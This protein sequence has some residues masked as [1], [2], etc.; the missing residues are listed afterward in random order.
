MGEL[1]TRGALNRLQPRIPK[2]AAIQSI[3]NPG[4]GLA[5]DYGVGVTILDAN[6]VAWQ[7]DIDNLTDEALK[8]PLGETYWWKA[9]C[10]DDSLTSKD[11][12]LPAKLLKVSD[13]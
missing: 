1:K 12:P 13:E 8:L 3:E 10:D 9:G 5:K 6:G 4:R 2:S 7:R 11:I